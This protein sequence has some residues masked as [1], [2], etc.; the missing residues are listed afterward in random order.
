MGATHT[1]NHRG[2]IVRQVRDLG[3]EVPIKYVFITHT[4]TSA[5]LSSCAQLLAPFG[6]VCSI[7][8]DTDMAM[9]AT[10]FMAKILTFVWALLGT[11]PFYGVDVESHGKILRELKRL[12]EEGRVKCHLREKVK[13]DEEGVKKA[14]GI[15]EGGG[16]VGKVGLEV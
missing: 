15:I 4:P 14:H 5:Y 12:V 6:A 9:Y 3:L 11:K 13:M 7:V 16:A 10:E 2:D 1:V 8:Q